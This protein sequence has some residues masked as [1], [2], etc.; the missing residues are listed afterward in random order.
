VL[1]II[2]KFLGWGAISIALITL[3]VSGGVYLT[4]FHPDA[5]EDEAI[6][7]SAVA[8]KLRPGQQLKILSWNLQFLAGRPRPGNNFFFDGGSDPWPSLQTVMANARA[9]ANII[10][11]ED[12]DVIL[13]QELDDGAERTHFK[14]Q[15]QLILS[16]VSTGRRILFHT[17][18]CW[19]VLA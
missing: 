1:R 12:P 18:S 3:L 4:T 15:L 10:R 16:L 14:D 5:I 13:L 9:V 2:S 6:I 19:V 7:S 11:Q 17:A 8:P